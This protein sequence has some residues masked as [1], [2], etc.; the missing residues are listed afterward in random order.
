V[1]VVN[2]ENTTLYLF[3]C[4]QIYRYSWME[5][6]INNKSV[7]VIILY[8]H[9]TYIY[10]F[11]ARKKAYPNLLGKKGYVVVVFL[12]RKKTLL[13]QRKLYKVMFSCEQNVAAISFSI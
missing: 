13:L 2:I 9:V 7:L 1:L 11:L 8:Y 6:I 12:A 5:F 10:I 3:S 4:I